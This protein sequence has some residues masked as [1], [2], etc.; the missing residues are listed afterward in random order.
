MYHVS[1]PP[2]HF[3]PSKIKLFVLVLCV[4]YYYMLRVCYVEKNGN[5]YGGQ[6]LGP[7]RFT[8]IES[9][10]REVCRSFKAMEEVEAIISELTELDATLARLRTELAAITAA[11]AVAASATATT[12]SSTTGTDTT[13]MAAAQDTKD[14]DSEIPK[15]NL[16]RSVE[17][18]KTLLSPPDVLKARR[19]LTARQNAI[20]SVNGVLARVKEGGTGNKE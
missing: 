2:S 8:H 9:C 1:F 17:Y 6:L 10:T 4:S 18:R 19:L 15:P 12:S 5:R 7:V 11:A 13:T 16:T 20:K 14:T 3:F